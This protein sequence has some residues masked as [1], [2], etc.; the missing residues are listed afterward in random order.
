MFNDV[1]IEKGLY[2]I[3]NKSFTQALEE[4]DPDSQ[5]EGT[6]LAALDAYERQ[7]KR[8]DIKI[9][10]DKCDKVEKF[11]TSTETAVLFPEFVRRAVLEGME[12]VSLSD[13]VAV[14]TRTHSRNYRGFSVNENGILYTTGTSEAATINKTQITES[15]TDVTL[16]KMGRL[17]CTS[18]EVIMRQNIDAYALTLKTIGVK[19]ANGIMAKA[20]NVL[21]SDASS[22][23]IASTALEYSDIARLYGTFSDFNMNAIIASPTVAAQILAMSPMESCTFDDK[24]R[25]VM[26][27]GAAIIKAS[28]LSSNYIIG[29][30][31][32]YALECVTTSDLIMETDKLI[33]K[34]LEEIAVTVNVA[35]NKITA[36]AVKVLVI[37][38]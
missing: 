34:Q 2:N 10:G 11:F 4:R 31:T 21:Y 33:D 27:F 25:P 7:L 22:I 35:F 37:S 9:S 20:L 38:K 29:L 8:F 26:P 14:N 28:T 1:V 13:I 24:N 30:D 17:I 19:L 3:A 23:D 5:Y 6:S 16:I 32:N 36:D 12:S 15:T 18:Y